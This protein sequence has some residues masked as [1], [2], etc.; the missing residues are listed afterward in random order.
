MAFVQALKKVGRFVMPKPTVVTSGRKLSVVGPGDVAMLLV[1]IALRG[2][3]YESKR[4]LDFMHGRRAQ[5]CRKP[6]KV[7]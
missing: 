6:V 5:N 7:A 1:R 2:P 4:V 3:R